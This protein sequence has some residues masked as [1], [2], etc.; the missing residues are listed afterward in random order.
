MNYKLTKPSQLQTEVKQIRKS[1]GLTQQKLADLLDVSRVT[2]T[3]FENGKSDDISMK[4]LLERFDKLG[5]DF[6]Y[7]LRERE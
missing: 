3:E 4:L 6:Y 1:K 5:I 7:E 2:I